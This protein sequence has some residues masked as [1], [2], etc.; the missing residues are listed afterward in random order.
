MWKYAPK[1]EHTGRRVVEIA[2]ASATL[3]FNE[4]QKAKKKL[5]ASLKLRTG[6]FFVRW[7]HKTDGK[8]VDQA[9]RRSRT[10][11]DRSGRVSDG[12]TSRTDD[13]EFYSAGAF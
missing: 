13:E 1:V 3:E 4:G 8:R 5:Y 7:I 2:V 6:K 12:D 11:D 9:E 10:R